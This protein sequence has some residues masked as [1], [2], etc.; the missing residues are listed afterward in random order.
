MIVPGTPLVQF[1]NAVVRRS[2]RTIL[3]VDDLTIH[4]GE[5]VAILG[6]NGA[7]KST[8]VQVI[9]RE[10]LPLYAEPAPVLWLGRDRIETGKLRGLCG[11]VS[12]RQQ[13]VLDVHLTVGEVVL[14][15]L[16]GALAVPLWAAV[17]DEDRAAAQA[18]IDEVGLSGFED[19]DLT[20]LSTGE[21]RR[22]A[23]ARALVHDPQVLVLDEPT[24]GLDPTAAWALRDTM[25]RVADTGRTLV[26]VTHHIEDIIDSIDRVI[27]VKDG[28]IVG[29]G[30][31][32][33]LLT[34]Q[35]ISALYNIPVTLEER[36][37]E[38]RLWEESVG[39]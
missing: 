14:A 34:S 10:V 5:R 11:V 4:A 21:A 13:W 38:Y 1:R 30:Q 6:P 15:A 28:R 9:T 26:L 39:T 35:S 2:G 33:E 37:G 36:N 20:T 17:T 18:A 29:D 12:S 24:A 7:G 32:R 23:V 3:S 16:Y 8:L 25:R 27:T 22:A 31:K 19:R